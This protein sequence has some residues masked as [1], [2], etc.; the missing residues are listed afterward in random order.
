MG[1]HN[2]AFG[3]NKGHK[4]TKNV[5]P[6]NTPT[7]AVLCQR[8][9]SLSVNLFVKFLDLLLMKD[10][11][12]NCFVLE[13]ISVPSDFAKNGLDVTSVPSE[14]EKKCKVPSKLKERLQLHKNNFLLA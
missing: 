3:L 4:V 14:S 12:W 10:A 9:P 6:R 2:M 5:Q 7:G 8:R 1:I 13:R 11:V